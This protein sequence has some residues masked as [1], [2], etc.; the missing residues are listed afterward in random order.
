MSKT[1]MVYDGRTNAINPTVIKVIVWKQTSCTES[2]GRLLCLQ[3]PAHGAAVCGNDCHLTGWSK[4]SACDK[5]LIRTSSDMST[6]KTT[7]DAIY[8][9]CI[10]P[11]IPSSFC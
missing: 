4:K 2:E 7:G 5:A 9:T 10:R 8:C 6:L 11:T 3:E 1:L